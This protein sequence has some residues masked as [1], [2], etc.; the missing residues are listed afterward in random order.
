[1]KTSINS[2]YQA[3]AS[4]STFRG[5]KPYRGS[6]VKAEDYK[7]IILRGLGTVWAR[8]E[9]RGADVEKRTVRDE[10]G[11]V[12]I[13]PRFALF[14]LGWGADAGEKGFWSDDFSPDEWA[15]IESELAS[16]T[17]KHTVKA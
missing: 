16:H 11:V 9:D 4:G 2:T 3:T 10:E 8:M 13:Y 6:D 12:H 14:V 5:F 1:M 7:Q 15:R 17:V